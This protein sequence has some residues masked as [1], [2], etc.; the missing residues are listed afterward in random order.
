MQLISVQIGTPRTVGTPHA[1]D[2]MERAFTSAIWKESV[3]GPVWAGVLGLQGDSVANTKV[4]GGPEQAILM[5]AESHYQS[6]RVEWGRDDLAAGAFGE[7][8]TAVG[9]DEDTVCIGDV[10]EIG[11]ARLQVSQPRQPCSTL[12]RRHQV[13]DMIARVHRNGRSGWYLRVL[14]EGHLEA[15]QP[16]ALV[17]RPH[18]EWTV[19]RAGRVGLDRK[20]RREDA[21]QLAA[22]S[23]LS[24]AWRAWLVRS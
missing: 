21:A 11:D 22:C 8:L 2:P 16:I 14:R 24:P 19:R 3:T 12:A 13:H 23:A 7:N 4:H 20:V 10:L 15:G 18:P 6:W 1:S 9:L 5:Y 17:D